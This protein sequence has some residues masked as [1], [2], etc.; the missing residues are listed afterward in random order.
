MMASDG[1]RF[2]FSAGHTPADTF[3]VVGF[4]LKQSLSSLFS[5][6]ITVACKDPAID[7]KNILDETATL[8]LWQGEEIKRRVRGIVTFCEQGDSGKHQ[9]LYTMSVRPEFWRSS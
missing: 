5:L 6:D 3:A 9:T 1:T 8:V 2:T 4:K 7:F